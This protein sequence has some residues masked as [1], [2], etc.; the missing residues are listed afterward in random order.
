MEKICLPMQEPWV[1]SLG[2]EDTQKEV[3]THPSI[4]TWEIPRTEDSGE[5]QSLGS[6]KSQIQLSNKITRT[7]FHRIY[8]PLLLYTYICQWTSTLLPCAG[9]CKESYSEH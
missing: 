2:Q 7:I 5:L 4:L 3:A 6:Q 1:Q 8:L 9:C